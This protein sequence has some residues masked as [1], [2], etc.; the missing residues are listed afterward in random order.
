MA[1]AIEQRK[2]AVGKEPIDV[3]HPGLYRK[4]FVLLGQ[5]GQLDGQS[6]EYPG[7]V[8]LVERG[9]AKSTVGSVKTRTV[10]QVIAQHTQCQPPTEVAVERLRYKGIITN[11]FVVVHFF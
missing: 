2:V 8:G 3:F 10:E 5:F 6:R 7:I 4:G 11:L 9:D 1:V